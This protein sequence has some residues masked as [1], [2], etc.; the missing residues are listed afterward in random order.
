MKGKGVKR[1]KQKVG[2]RM[3]WIRKKGEEEHL[4]RFIVAWKPEFRLESWSPE[5]L[6]ALGALGAYSPGALGAWSP[7]AIT[8]AIESWES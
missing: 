7:G 2:K 6:G 8:G 4:I 5:A 1:T 3:N